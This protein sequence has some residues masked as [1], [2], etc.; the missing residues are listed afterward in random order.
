M[1]I[2]VIPAKGKHIK[3]IIRNVDCHVNMHDYSCNWKLLL[4][5]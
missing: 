1:Y 3:T 5:T 4:S 2:K